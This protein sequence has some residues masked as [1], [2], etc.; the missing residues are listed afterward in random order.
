MVICVLDLLVRNI[1]V[2]S[3]EVC[4]G[5]I[6]LSLSQ[7]SGY[8]ILALGCLHDEKCGWVKANEIAE[9]TGIPSAYLSKLLHKLGQSG[10][11]VAKRGTFGGYALSRAPSTISLFEVVE[12]IEGEQT[13]PICLL[14]LSECCDDNP[15]PAHEF[16]LKER[17]RIEKLLHK[18]KLK[19]VAT[20]ATANSCLA[21]GTCACG[22]SSRTRM[23]VEKN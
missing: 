19:E 18:T 20:F 22:R 3:I 10:L 16:W 21:P 7:T 9:C 4:T 23:N 2:L 12:A 1:Y 11:V 15:C 13:E 8:A 17:G 6:M 14:G 5:W